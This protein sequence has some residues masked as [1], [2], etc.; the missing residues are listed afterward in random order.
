MQI[1]QL[2]PFRDFDSVWL[3]VIENLLVTTD[4]N[5]LEKSTN[6]VWRTEILRCLDLLLNR[7]KDSEKKETLGKL[8]K[9]VRSLQRLSQIPNTTTQLGH[10]L[11]RA[12]DILSS[13]EEYLDVTLNQHSTIVQSLPSSFNT[14]IEIIHHLWQMLMQLHPNQGAS[15]FP[16]LTARMV[17]LK[18]LTL[19]PFNFINVESSDGE[20]AFIAGSEFQDAVEWVSSETL[21]ILRTSST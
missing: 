15:S 21:M 16:A 10:A 17:A 14:W 4:H 3:D 9:A 12:V 18:S 6:G 13:V 5:R 1:S 7:L 19:A 8:V 11:N 2:N 20:G